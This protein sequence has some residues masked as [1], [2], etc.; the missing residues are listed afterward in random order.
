MEFDY[1]ANNKR[2][3]RIQPPFIITLGVS[4]RVRTMEIIFDQQLNVPMFE[5]CLAQFEGMLKFFKGYHEVINVKD[6]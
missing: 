2:D 4:E 3:K 1:E 5:S 6:S